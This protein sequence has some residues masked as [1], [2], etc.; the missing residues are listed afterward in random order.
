M[1]LVYQYIKTHEYQRRYRYI[2][3]QQHREFHLSSAIKVIDFGVLLLFVDV[4][5][6]K[7]VDQRNR[8]IERMLLK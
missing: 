2:Y 1:L 5:V 3:M 7:K 6:E 4:E 8:G